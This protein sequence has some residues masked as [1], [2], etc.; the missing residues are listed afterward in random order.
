MKRL[1]EVTGASM[2]ALEGKLSQQNEPEEKRYKRIVE[3]PVSEQDPDVHQDYLIGLALFDSS[4]HDTLRRLTPQD[5]TGEARQAVLSYIIAHLH[6][7]ITVTL[8]S[9]LQPYETYVKIVLFKAETRYTSIDSAERLIEAASLVRYIQD[10]QRIQ[11]KKLLDKALWDAE[12]A[13][14]DEQ[15]QAI[16]QALAALIKEKKRA[17]R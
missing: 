17:P 5:V 12:A 8:P 10:E 13:H 14:D 6:E 11:K 7:D 16:R 4:V 1:S 2:K 9:D 15:A 3:Q